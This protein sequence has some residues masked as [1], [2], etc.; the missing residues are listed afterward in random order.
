MGAVAVTSGGAVPRWGKDGKQLFYVAPDLTL[1]SVPLTRA[2]TELEVG[3][4]V[5]VFQSRAFQGNREYDV[6]T[7]GRFLLNVPVDE[8]SDTS[9]AVIV[10]WAAGLKKQKACD[11][12]RRPAYLRSTP[13]CIPVGTPV[14]PLRSVPGARVG[15]CT[16]PWIV[17]S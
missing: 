10:N 14:P 7:D 16:G 11:S 13:G 6:S 5:R 12:E 9:L 1:M 15:R 4:P 3:K 17:S 2:G 8:R